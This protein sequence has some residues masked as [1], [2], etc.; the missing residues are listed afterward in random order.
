MDRVILSRPLLI[1]KT[2]YVES[3]QSICSELAQ[4]LADMIIYTFIFVTFVFVLLVFNKLEDTKIPNQPHQTNI[5]RV[6]NYSLI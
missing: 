6:L 5:I 3:W 4:K 1:M 2:N